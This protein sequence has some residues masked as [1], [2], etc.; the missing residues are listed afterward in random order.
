MS[1]TRK[2][3][4]VEL[5]LEPSPYDRGRAALER[6][7]VQDVPPPEPPRSEHGRHREPHVERLRTQLA[8]KFTSVADEVT[9]AFADFHI[10]AGA[11][12]AE[13][14]APA[15]MSTKGGKHALQ[16]LRLRA[17]R[18]GHHVLVGGLV[19]GVQKL[20]QLRDYEHMQLIYRARFDKPLEITAG[21]WE[22]FLRKAEVVLRGLGIRTVRVSAPHDLIMLAESAERGALKQRL[23]VAGLAVGVMLSA[24]VI[25]R[26][27]VVLWP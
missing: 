2:L 26:V 25:W 5:G 17:T 20:A 8:R 10:G 4:K 23:A 11:W 22:Q 7:I 24:L 9:E 13:L 3:T 1:G 16:H 21:E 15:G 6:V 18:Q 12:T 14:T 19:N 27:V